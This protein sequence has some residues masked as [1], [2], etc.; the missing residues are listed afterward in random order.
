MQP[1][2]YDR[3][4]LYLPPLMP[5]QRPLSFL[6]FR[7]VSPPFLH[8][9]WSAFGLPALL[10]FALTTKSCA[11]A[12]LLPLLTNST[13]TLCCFVNIK[14]TFF[15]WNSFSVHILSHA[16][17]VV[18]E[19]GLQRELLRVV[20]ILQP[21]YYF[22]YIRNSAGIVGV[23]AITVGVPVITAGVSPSRTLNNFEINARS[24]DDKVN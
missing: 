21:T 14:N 3:P 22:N 5:G 9:T 18:R 8:R 6:H 10:N 7:P 11:C 19:N 24:Q 15:A 20:W 17:L 23:P 4:P 1:Y 13:V 16:K 12:C 2:G